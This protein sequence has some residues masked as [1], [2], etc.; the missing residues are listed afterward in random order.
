M[1]KRQALQLI[2]QLFTQPF[3]LDK[4]RHFVRNLLNHYE[5][6]SGHYTG[7]YIPDAFKQ[8]V[9]QYWRIGK[10]VD[11]DGNQLDLLVVEVKS[12]A[13]LERARSSLRN[14]A[15]NRL[16]QFE[17]E[18]SLIAFYAQDDDGAD[19]R[20]SFV[21]IEHEAYLDEKG[22][23]KLKQELTPAR[24]YSYLVGQH[25]NS[26]TAC[27]QLLPILEMDYANPK[28]EEIEAAFSIEK[29]TD[30]FFDQYK[31]LFQK[32][33]EHLKKQPW[34]KQASDEETDQAVSRFAKKL[35]GQI[36]FLYFLQKKGWLGAAKG[37]AWG[38][39]SKRFLRER[40]D[41]VAKSGNNYYRDFL[42]YLFY[43]A[44]ACKREEQD[45]P[46]Y[47]ERF[48]C[49]VPFLNGGLFE[50]DY[51][52]QQVNIEIPNSLFHNDE[53]TKEGDVGTGILDVFDRYNFTIKEDEP[54]DKEVAVDPEMLGKVFENMLEIT[55]RKSKG[56]F[57]TPREIVHYMCQESLIHYLDNRLNS[58]ATS[59]QEFGSPQTSLFGNAIG[60]GQ[61]KLTAEHQDIK[62][63]KEDIET[64]IRKGHLALENDT[65]V[66]SKGRET[67]DYKFQL[68]ESVRTY[69]K[70][71]DEALADIKVCDPAIGSG[72]FP[73]G[74]LHEIVN[75]RQAL[76]PH[77]GNSQS[78]YELKRHAIAESIYGVDIDAS[79]IDIARLRLW[80]S[81]IVD[82]ENYDT[83]AALPNLDYK[84]VRGDSLLGIEVDLFNQ[85]LFNDIEA[86]KKDFFSTTD[87]VEKARL[88]AEINELI[89]KLTRGSELFDFKVYFSEV[90]H[91]KG[92]FDVVIGNPP[93]VQ[94]QKFSGQQVQKEW[95]AQKYESFAK[96]GDI[97]CLFYEKSYRLLK[98]RGVLA[99]ITSNKWM[100][101]A[102]G[103]KLRRFFAEKTQP[104]TLVDFS[105]FQV[106]ETATVDTN[107]LLFEKSKR[108]RPVRACLISPAF[109][110]STPLDA[111]VEK[112]SIELDELSSDSWVISDKRHY[113]IKKRIEQVG[114]PLKEWDIAIN[115]G[116]KTGFNEA[117]IIDG[118]KKDELISADPKSAE[119][120]K[121]ILRGRD[122]KRYRVDFA[123]LWLI[124]AKYG[125]YKTLPKEYPVIYKHLSQYEERL[126]ARGQCRYTS[127]GRAKGGDY[128]GQHHWLELDNN[129]HDNY[130]AEFEREKITWGNL[131]LNCQFALAEKDI[132]VSAPSPIISGGDRYLLAIL[133]SSVGDY[134]IRS[135]GVTRNG[136]YF[137]YKPM[138]VENLPVPKSTT[139]RRRPFETLADYVLLSTKHDQKLQSAYFEQLI[140]G[141]AYELYFPDELKSAGKDILRHLGELTPISDEMSDEEKLAIIQREFDRLYDP[142]HPV[143]NIIETLDS[144][145]VVRTIR[146]ALKR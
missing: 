137:E 25:E 95:E 121:P 139:S 116:I 97:Y 30:E 28:V 78:A 124:V 76:A 56:A 120:I 64:L 146:E 82:E 80:L 47:Y 93:Y 90:W 107:V 135:L 83:I 10:Y 127:S 141:L 69:A 102:Y 44:L 27:K 24:R 26:H 58:Y 103:K 6:R 59:Y 138:F 106:F 92:G 49:R 52:W 40:Y 128:P 71:I 3:E 122:I 1:D 57:Y 140:D 133:N 81:L 129:P 143:R 5:E 72:A 104:L 100:R 134:Y 62:V 67:R 73:V 20:F 4:Y 70:D 145:E 15:V 8:H 41:Q 21:K 63:P 54:L 131:A 19:W 23:V 55:E 114:T 105:S 2:Q 109:T 34:F 94:I 50:A 37:K 77:S 61:L 29:V 14:F 13:K 130:L 66:L 119:I 32:L 31:A 117:F 35:L 96:R 112:N 118:Q 36:V 45:D 85:H 33:A 88:A 89:H 79:A 18:A 38:E 132:F 144:V 74:L 108:S 101:A 11:P 125:S 87:H 98:D 113:D 111:F 16:K 110:R 99:F 136:G 22:K 126:K 75:A 53:K 48:Q 9:N 17:K 39:G 86:K 115:Y 12:L 123:D 65:R 7:N 42:Q 84:I 43:E 142:R 60:K 51:D 46:G 91:Q 68:P